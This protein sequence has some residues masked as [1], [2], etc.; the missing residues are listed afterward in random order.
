MA[1]F[2]VMRAHGTGYYVVDVQAEIL[3]SLRS[4]IVIPLVPAQSMPGEAAPRL[5]PILKFNGGEYV[6]NTPEMAAV[7]WPRLGEPVGSLS[8]QD[9]I[10][11][12]AID[13]VL[14]GF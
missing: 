6:L 8:H 2:D 9:T 10:I 12:D 13:F 7:P 5:R 4:R 14:Q 3:R 1:R 11:V